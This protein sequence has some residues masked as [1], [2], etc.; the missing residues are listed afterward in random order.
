M[1]SA[2]VWLF[3]VPAVVGVV[4]GLGDQSAGPSSTNRQRALIH[5]DGTPRVY[6]T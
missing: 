6:L 1:T 5:Q 3:L 2:R 4:G